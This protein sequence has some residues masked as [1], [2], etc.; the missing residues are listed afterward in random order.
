ML[1]AEGQEDADLITC[2]LQVSVAVRNGRREPIGVRIVRQ[3][4]IRVRLHS[5]LLQYPAAVGA[6]CLHTQRKFVSHFLDG[7]AG[8]DHPEHLKF[9]IGKQFVKRQLAPAP[10]IDGKSFRERGAD[11]TPTRQ[12]FLDGFLQLVGNAVL[13]QITGGAGFEGAP[14]KLLFGMHG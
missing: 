11:V 12:D 7:L 14:R 3:D 6:D 10:Q 8:R 1:S 2:K 13:G 5:S 9:A 4:Q